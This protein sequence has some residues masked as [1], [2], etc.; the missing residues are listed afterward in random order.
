MRA[1]LYA[2]PGIPAV[3]PVASR[4]RTLAEQWLGRSA[5]GHA[6]EPATPLGHSRSSIDAITVD[7]RRYGF[8]GTL[9]APFRLARGTTLDELDSAVARFAARRRLV[10]VPQLTLTRMDGFFALVPGAPAPHL[11]ALANDVVVRFDRFRAPMSDAERERRD[12][13][14][15]TGRQRELLT[16]HGYPYVLDEFRFHCT[17]T[18]RIPPG[19]RPEV[20]RMLR[21]WFDEVLGQDVPLDAIALF[22]EPEPGAPFQLHTTHRLH[23]TLTSRTA[24]IPVSEGPR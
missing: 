5:A 10:A 3:N 9:K 2:A 24:E 17:L 15:L 8:H 23:P 13:A 11:H 14:G 16:A 18:D 1:A 7:A 22:V 12:V 19:Q 6:V 4:L 21:S 20:E